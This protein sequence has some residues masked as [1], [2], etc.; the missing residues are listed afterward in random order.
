MPGLKQSL[1]NFTT[2]ETFEIRNATCMIDCELI[3]HMGKT[4]RTLSIRMDQDP[5]T[6]IP[7]PSRPKDCLSLDALVTLGSACAWL[8]ELTVDSPGEEE[9]V[10]PFLNSEEAE[11]QR[12]DNPAI[13]LAV[14]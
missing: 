9:K 10:L 2:L 8:Q 6:D 14:R 11:S 1:L 3:S 13:A 4:L 5:N 12:T 7:T